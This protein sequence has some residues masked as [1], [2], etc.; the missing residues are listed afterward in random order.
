MTGLLAVVAG[1]GAVVVAVAVA[2]AE[3]SDVVVGRRRQGTTIAGCD[4]GEEVP[5]RRRGAAAPCGRGSASERRS[6]ASASCI[7]GSCSARRTVARPW[8]FPYARRPATHRSSVLAPCGSARAAYP[9]RR[10]QARRRAHALAAAGRHARPHVLRIDAAQAA[11]AEVITLVGRYGVST[12]AIQLMRQ[13]VLHYLRADPG[14]DL[15]RV[16]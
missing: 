6:G 5:P 10:W 1:G 8:R 3:S 4:P 13:R 9:R 7:C 12:A 2:G 14:S 11:A 15:P 16:K